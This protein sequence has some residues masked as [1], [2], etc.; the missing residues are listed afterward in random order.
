MSQAPTASPPFRT[1]PDLSGRATWSAEGTF[2]SSLLDV[3][4]LLARGLLRQ[5]D[6]WLVRE[7]SKRPVASR[8]GCTTCKWWQAAASS[9][10]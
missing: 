10:L 3:R 9:P 1:L 2:F 7:A 4:E 5:S 6:R 8:G